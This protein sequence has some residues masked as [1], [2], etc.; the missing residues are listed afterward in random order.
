M[1]W[2]GV[3]LRLRNNNTA[4]QQQRNWG[5]LGQMIV[6]QTDRQETER[7]DT[8]WLVKRFKHTYKI[9]TKECW[10]K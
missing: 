8:R 1:K 5:G 7:W 3:A 2:I 4:F 10:Q 9:Q 6:R